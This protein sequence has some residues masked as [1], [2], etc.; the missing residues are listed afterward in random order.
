MAKFTRRQ[1]LVGTLAASALSSPLAAL[2]QCH[3]L[4]YL[5]M[6]VRAG[7]VVTA[8]ADAAEAT[9]TYGENVA[10]WEQ[11]LAASKTALER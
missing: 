10:G 2:A 1:V 11:E 9:R 6:A 3:M 7:V 5:H 8:Y 4:S